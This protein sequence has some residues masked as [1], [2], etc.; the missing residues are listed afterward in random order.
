MRNSRIYIIVVTWNGMKWLK[1]CMESIRRSTVPVKTIVIDNGSADDTCEFIRKNYPGVILLETGKNLG[2][3]QANNVGIRYAYDN[4]ADYVYL[5]NQDAYVYPDMFEKLLAVSESPAYSEIGI[6][7]PLH[8]HGSRSKLDAQFKGYLRAI[9]TDFIEDNSVGQ[10]KDVY[11]VEC[12]PAA[13]WF[14][15]RST[16]EKIGGFDPIFFHYGEDHH[17]AQRVNYHGLKVGVVPSAKMIHDREGFGNETMAK[18]NRILRDLETEIFLN[19]NYSMGQ[20]VYKFLNKYFFFSLYSF[21]EMRSGNWHILWEEFSSFFKIL[22]RQNKYRKN[23]KIN[24]Q[25]GMHWL[26]ESEITL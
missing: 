7:S 24:K 25:L 15:P 9:G 2:F 19:I 16:I 4:G 14:I 17:Y 6:F 22:I 23:R 5:L 1:E 13:G 3:G 11:C 8:V 10:P 20:R 18:R 26:P 12:V 21:E